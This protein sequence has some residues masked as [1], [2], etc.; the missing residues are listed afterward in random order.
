MIHGSICIK[1]LLFLLVSFLIL[2]DQSHLHFS[3][4]IHFIFDSSEHLIKYDN[5]D[6]NA[7]I[8]SNISKVENHNDNKLSVTESNHEILHLTTGIFSMSDKFNSILLWAYYTNNKGFVIEFNTERLIANRVNKIHGPFPMQYVKELKQ[9]SLN[10]Y[11]MYCAFMLKINIKDSQWKHE[12]EWRL[13]VESEKGEYF[14]HPSMNIPFACERKSY[15]NTDVIKSIYL[16]RNFFEKKELNVIDSN[17]LYVDLVNE[18]DK[19]SRV[20]RFIIQNKIKTYYWKQDILE[21]QR[22]KCVIQ[23]DCNCCFRIKLLE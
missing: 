14:K 21:L 23:Q 17:T 11:D 3:N 16:G 20:L 2:K 12:N 8:E 18:I 1:E 15:Y 9:I 22:I 7:I 13:I 5:E 4:T 6:I 19:K 10:K